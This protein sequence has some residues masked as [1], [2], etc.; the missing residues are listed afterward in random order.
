M[1]LST[2][3]DANIRLSQHV[4]TQ[5]YKSKQSCATGRGLIERPIVY[6]A[7]RT[8]VESLS[9]AEKYYEHNATFVN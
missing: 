3:A 4:H 1:R 5:T 7:C 9:E 6:W 8:Q 2:M